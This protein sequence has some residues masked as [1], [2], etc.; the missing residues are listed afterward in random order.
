MKSKCV[1]YN[2]TR[3]FHPIITE[4]ILSPKKMTSMGWQTLWCNLI[5]FTPTEDHYILTIT[6]HVNQIYAEW[7]KISAN[8]A[9]SE[10]EH[11]VVG[12]NNNNYFIL[13]YF[14]IIEQPNNT[15]QQE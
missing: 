11:N 10:K 8:T 14:S 6:E 4:E 3:G 5:W 9:Y 7:N 12:Q 2:L 1:P 15:T 13:F